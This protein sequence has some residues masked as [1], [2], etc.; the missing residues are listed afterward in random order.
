MVLTAHAYIVVGPTGTG[1]PGDSV[2]GGPGKS[3]NRM[4]IRESEIKFWE[5][6]FYGKK[7]FDMSLRLCVILD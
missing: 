6:G 7:G 5:L 1:G 4:L 3:A 2:G